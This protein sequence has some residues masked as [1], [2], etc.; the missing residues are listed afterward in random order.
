MT[1]D[2]LIGVDSSEPIDF[3]LAA[4]AAN[5]R[6][7]LH[8]EIARAGVSER[9][10]RRRVASG[11]W[12]GERR[13]VLAIN[14]VPPSFEQVVAGA[15]MSRGGGVLTAGPTAARMWTMPGNHELPGINLLTIDPAKARGPGIVTHRTRLL[16]PADRSLVRGIP[17]T[18]YARTLLDNSGRRD[19]SDRQ[20]GWILDHGVRTGATTLEAVRST[21]ARLRPARGRR[22]TRIRALLEARGVDF[23]PGASQPEVRLAD[24]L[25]GAGFGRPVHGL[26]I[27]A[28]GVTWELD[29]AYPEMKVCFDYHSEAFHA[30]DGSVPT[31]H[32]DSRKANALKKAGWDYSWFTSQST[33]ADVVD[34]IGYA[35][36]S[37]TVAM[38]ACG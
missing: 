19:L 33:E 10:V 3:T 21:T 14:G 5:H 25:E 15:T 11:Q 17:T 9:T 22:T 37:R 6:G 13:S 29:G 23:D 1:A 24:W 4:Y 18:S 28:D 16:V 7:L 30:G 12:R 32:K 20:L 26:R 8:T 2:R 38:S 31:F 35:L 27:V 36:V 34:V